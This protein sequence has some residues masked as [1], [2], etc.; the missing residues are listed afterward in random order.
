MLESFYTTV[1]RAS[2]T[3]LA[4]WRVRFQPSEAER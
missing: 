4:L 2:F 3:L 1:A